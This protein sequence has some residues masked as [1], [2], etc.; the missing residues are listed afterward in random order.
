MFCN[1][2]QMKYSMWSFFC[3]LS[4]K[5]VRLRIVDHHFK[6][7]QIYRFADYCKFN[8]HYFLCL[9]WPWTTNIQA[10]EA[11]SPPPPKDMEQKKPLILNDFLFFSSMTF[12]LSIYQVREKT[13]IY[14][15]HSKRYTKPLLRMHSQ[16]FNMLAEVVWK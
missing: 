3:A 7:W 12:Y 6:Y 8:Y 11:P 1:K 5:I 10:L 4:L 16:D 9:T 13:Y 14:C 2:V 15:W